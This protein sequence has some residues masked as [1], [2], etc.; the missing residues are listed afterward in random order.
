M[1]YLNKFVW[2]LFNPAFV[3]VALLL[4]GVL[5]SRWR[6]GRLLSLLALVWFVF[7]T[8]PLTSMLLGTPLERGYLVDGAIPSVESYTNADAIVVLGGGMAVHQD[9]DGT[10]HAEMNANSDRVWMGARLFRAEK[11]PKIVL[12]SSLVDRST[13]PL[14]RDLGVDETCIE[15]HEEPRNTEEEARFLATNGVRRILLVT[16]AWHMRR[17][18]LMFRRYAPELEIVPAPA[19][20]EYTLIKRR[21][22][23]TEGSARLLAFVPDTEALWRNAVA[24]KEWVG[25]IGYRFFR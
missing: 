21:D 14:L 5:L 7:W 8:L 3:G 9:P 2:F 19:D 20:W 15:Y 10:Y 1:Y 12:T 6:L 22:D 24:F 23:G 18:E 25:Y 13:I 16:S 17:A 4:V 11:A